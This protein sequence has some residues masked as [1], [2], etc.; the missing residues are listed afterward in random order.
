MRFSLIPFKSS[1]ALPVADGHDF[2]N[3]LVDYALVFFIL[4]CRDRLPCDARSRKST[5]ANG[6]GMIRA[7]LGRFLI[8]M[9]TR[10]CIP[11]DFRIS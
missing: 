11:Y 1:R 5:N 7:R 6:G 2:T 8:F 4:V 3:R 9:S 10:R